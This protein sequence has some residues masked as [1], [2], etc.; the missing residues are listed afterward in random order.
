[1]RWLWLIALGLFATSAVA[2]ETVLVGRVVGVHDGDTIT[3][4]TDGNKSV[5][6]RLD[7]IDAPESK[8]AFGARAKETLSDLVFGKTV[9]VRVRTTDRYGRTI[10]RVQVGGLDVNVE[11]VRMGFA[12][13]YRAYAKRDTV[14]EA[15][16]SEARRAGR[17]LWTDKDAVPPWDWRK[18]RGSSRSTERR[19]RP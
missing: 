4:L 13:W 15:A 12:W 16:E 8:Q 9:A 6:V 11:M 1:M 18:N 17:G 7:G 10:G 19:G 5:K 3:V 14:L 2:R